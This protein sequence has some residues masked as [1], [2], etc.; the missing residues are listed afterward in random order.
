MWN[1][2]ICIWEA[3]GYLAGLTAIKGQ[4]Y[5]SDTGRSGAMAE[6]VRDLVNQMV[7]YYL[8]QKGAYEVYYYTTGVYE[9]TKDPQRAASEGLAYAYRQFLE[10]KGESSGEKQE[11]YSQEAGFFQMLE[12]RAPEEEFRR[13]ARLLEENWRDF[14]AALALDKEGKGIVLRMQRYSPWGA[15]AEAEER[16]RERDQKAEQIFLKQALVVTVIALLYFLWRFFLR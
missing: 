11:A 13:G 10:K 2:R 16:R 7:D 15:L 14:L 9:K 6:P 1:A 8:N 3:A 12:G 5:S 4:I